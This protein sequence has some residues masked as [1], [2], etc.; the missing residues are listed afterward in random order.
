MTCKYIFT[1]KLPK[2]PSAE[3]LIIMII[4]I[5]ERR[6]A[7]KAERGGKNLDQQKDRGRGAAPA[8]C[9]PIGRWQRGA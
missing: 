3:A 5:I 6:E 2:G 7:E 8:T 4:I 1:L 9:C